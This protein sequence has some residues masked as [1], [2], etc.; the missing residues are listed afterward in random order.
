[1]ATS[2]DMHR[3]SSGNA[4]R[5]RPPEAP[6][7]KSASSREAFL[8]PSA[9]ATDVLAEFDQTLGAAGIL[10]KEHPATSSRPDAQI[11]LAAVTW[12]S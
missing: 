4:F 7:G 6:V 8:E 9:A 2:N 3:R 10:L 12:Q 1:M 11:N 5:N